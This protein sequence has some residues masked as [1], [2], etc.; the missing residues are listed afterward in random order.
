VIPK[1]TSPHNPQGNGIAERVIKTL[2]TALRKYANK[3]GI[4]GN[5]NSMPHSSAGYSP[6]Y[7]IF[8]RSPLLSIEITINIVLK[9]AEIKQDNRLIKNN[10]V[11]TS[12]NIDIGHQVW[13]LDKKHKH[14]LLSRWTGLFTVSTSI[15]IRK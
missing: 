1:L 14:G 13:Y 5:Y 7:L 6:F 3:D 9:Q 8:N 15:P 10:L 2:K 4:I 12:R 11:D